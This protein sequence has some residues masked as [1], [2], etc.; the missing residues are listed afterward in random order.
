MGGRFGYHENEDLTYDYL[1]DKCSSFK[2]EDEISI[3]FNEIDD[4]YRDNSKIIYSKE[5]IENILKECI[6]NMVIEIEDVIDE[7][8]E[9]Y[10]FIAT[11]NKYI[12]DWNEVLCSIEVNGKLVEV[13][14]TNDYVCDDANNISSVYIT[15]YS[16]GKGVFTECIERINQEYEFIGSTY[17]YVPV[18]ENELC[19]KEIDTDKFI[20]C[21]ISEINRII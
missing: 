12:D 9:K 8:F 16:G 14:L 6:E 18:S 20:E 17:A 3:K 10:D 15:L 11:Y 5:E 2:E 21:I 19:F 4:V 1:Y 13:K 7:K